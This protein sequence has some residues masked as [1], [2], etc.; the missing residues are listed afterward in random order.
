MTTMNFGEG[1]LGYDLR[2]PIK[3]QGRWMRVTGWHLA[4]TIS[5]ILVHLLPQKLGISDKRDML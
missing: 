1:G 3:L 2:E 4:N 5:Y